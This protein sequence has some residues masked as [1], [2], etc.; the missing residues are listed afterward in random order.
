MLQT[1]QFVQQMATGTG[2]SVP[3]NLAAHLGQA[4]VQQF[5]PTALGLSGGGAEDFSRVAKGS[6]GIAE[7]VHMMRFFPDTVVVNFESFAMQRA[8]DSHEGQPWSLEAIAR[9]HIAKIEGH[10]TLCKT[11]VILAHAYEMC[12]Q[13]PAP[14]NIHVR[15]FLGQAFKA[16]LDASNAKG[17]WKMSWPLLGIADPDEN[18]TTL[19]TPTERVALAAYQK[20]LLVLEK[21]RDTATAAKKD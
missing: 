8:G 16:S 9:D 17:S 14:E 4:G 5:A 10:R 12:R 13:R 3:F 6:A 11:I 1:G 7:M 15:A 18:S 21:A 2:S 20:E 19:T